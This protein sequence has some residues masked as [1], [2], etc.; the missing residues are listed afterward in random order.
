[1]TDPV[2]NRAWLTQDWSVNAGAPRLQLMLVLFRLAQALRR[3]FDRRCRIIAL[4]I[5]VLYTWYAEALCSVELPVRTRVGPR[6]RVRH[7]FGI[8]FNDACVVGADVEVRHGVTLGNK[9]EGGACPTLEDGVS[10]GVNATV[11]GGVRIGRGAIVGAGAVVVH[12]V[13]PGVTVVGT[14]AK[15]V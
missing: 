2:L 9:V 7:G 15:P 6:L 12:D 1:M 10:L 11:L 14:P 3:P 13:A 8:V 4:P 5:V